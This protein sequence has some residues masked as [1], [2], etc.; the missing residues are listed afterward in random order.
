[1]KAKFPN[2]LFSF[3]RV[4]DATRD[5]LEAELQ[6][7]LDQSND[8]FTIDKILTAM[9]HLFDRWERLDHERQMKRI[10]IPKRVPYPSGN[11]FGP[12][13]IDFERRAKVLS[14]AKTARIRRRSSI[15]N[16]SSPIII[17]IKTHPWMFTCCAGIF[18]GWF[19]SPLSWM[20]VILLI[21]SGIYLLSETMKRRHR[22]PAGILC[23]FLLFMLSSGIAHDILDDDQPTAECRDG[24]YSYSQHRQGTCSWHGG[25]GEWGPTMHHWWQTLLGQ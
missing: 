3:D 14:D 5:V 13:T 23:V 18:A 21:C 25:V 17:W 9:V 20:S 2:A 24:S 7:S 15:E 1:M 10:A 4:W 12:R 8:V 19:L 22:M 11:A 6:Q 16:S